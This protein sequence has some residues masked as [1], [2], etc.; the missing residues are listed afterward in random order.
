[1]GRVRRAR[2]R[3][4]GSVV[5][6]QRQG[7]VGE[8]AGAT[9]RASGKAVGGGAHPS[10]SAAWKWWRMLQAA[11]FNGGEAALV[12]DDGDGVALQCRGRR[13]KVRGEP[14]W[15]ERERVVVLT[16]NGG[17]WRCSGGNQRGGGVSGGGSRRGGRVG[18]G[19]GGEL[20]LGRGRR[21]KQSEALESSPNRRVRG[22]SREGNGG[23]GRL[24]ATRRKENG[25][26]RGGPGCGT[27]ART[28]W[29]RWL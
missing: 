10:G 15:M 18:G 28:A 14:I 19:E 17:R 12:M 24:G 5:P 3:R 25:R 7:A 11:A 29:S 1:M 23:G 9:R 22:E 4:G 6:G 13:E 21:T 2:S 26:E 20:E 8:L 27:V 16:D